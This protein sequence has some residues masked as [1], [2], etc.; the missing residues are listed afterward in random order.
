MSEQLKTD[1][2]NLRQF[3]RQLRADYNQA[4]FQGGA[5]S[6]RLDRTRR[7]RVRDTQARLSYLVPLYR[8]LV[9]AIQQPSGGKGAKLYAK[10]LDALR[11]LLRESANYTLV[12]MK[13]STYFGGDVL[14]LQLPVP[15]DCHTPTCWKSLSI[16]ELRLAVLEQLTVDHQARLERA[17]V[18]EAARRVFLGCLSEGQRTLLQAALIA[19][20]AKGTHAITIDDRDLESQA[21]TV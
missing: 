16:G 11:G 6:W 9:A 15:A 1:L 19:A 13:D 12:G 4:R 10:K 5:K 20:K 8:A 3:I 14:L 21:T 18:A 17:R 2:A 7:D